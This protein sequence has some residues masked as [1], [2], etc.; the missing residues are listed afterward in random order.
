MCG[1]Q[2]AS[3]TPL[4]VRPIC[5]AWILR[6]RFTPHRMTAFRPRTPREIFFA[7]YAFFAVK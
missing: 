4:S 6:L 2:I 3:H 1:R 5:G 7:L